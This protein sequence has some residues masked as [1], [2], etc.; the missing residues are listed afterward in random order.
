MTRAE[1]HLCHADGCRRIVAPRLLMCNEHWRMV[2]RG[3]QRRIWATYVPGQE[4]SKQPTADY[5]AAAL[6]AVA[7]VAARGQVLELGQ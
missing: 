7:A 3:I 2:P 4:I 1:H 6:A 5:L